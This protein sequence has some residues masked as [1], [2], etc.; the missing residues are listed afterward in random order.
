MVPREVSC[1]IHKSKRRDKCV[2]LI[3]RNSET[4]WNQSYLGEKVLFQALSETDRK[5]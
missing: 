3:V 1:Y 5:I 4:C 2:T